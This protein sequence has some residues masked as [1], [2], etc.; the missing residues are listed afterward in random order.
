MRASGEAFE[1]LARAEVL[2]GRCWSAP[3][4]AGGRVFVRNAEEI[5]ALELP[6]G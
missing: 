5:V 3:A 6:T 1:E 4:V 2:D